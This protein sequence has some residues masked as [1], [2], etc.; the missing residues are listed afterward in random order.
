MVVAIWRLRRVGQDTARSAGFAGRDLH[1]ACSGSAATREHGGGPLQLRDCDQ[2][3]PRL[4]L[5]A[6]SLF[7]DWLD[8]ERAHEMAQIFRGVSTNSNNLSRLSAIH[9][10]RGS[11]VRRSYG[12]GRRP[13]YEAFLPD[14]LQE[15]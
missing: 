3:L 1:G 5:R 4:T 2:A 9:G 8:T 15:L 14:P 7:P 11:P 10:G 13:E 6:R 12:V